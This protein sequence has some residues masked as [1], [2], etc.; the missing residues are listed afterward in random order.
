MLTNREWWQSRLDAA[1]ETGRQYDVTCTWSNQQRAV[2]TGFIA[3]AVHRLAKTPKRVVDFGAGRGRFAEV[4]K[5][6]WGAEYVG[7][8][9]LPDL[10]DEICSRGYEGHLYTGEMLPWAT[11]P[12]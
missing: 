4:V 3:A 5:K 12:V 7:V 1:F 6:D 2:D 9:I 8:E 11:T 10:V